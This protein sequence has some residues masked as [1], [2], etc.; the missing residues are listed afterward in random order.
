MCT[1]F[2]AEA[3]G[4]QP[5]IINI[6]GHLKRQFFANVM[7]EGIHET[8]VMLRQEL[9]NIQSKF[10]V[11]DRV[12]EAVLAHN[13]SLEKTNTQLNTVVR[14]LMRRLTISEQGQSTTDHVEATR[15]DTSTAADGS[16]NFATNPN[17][18]PQ[19]IES[20]ADGYYVPNENE[21]NE[22]LLIGMFHLCCRVQISDTLEGETI[23]VGRNEEG[24]LESVKESSD[25]RKRDVFQGVRAYECRCND[26]RLANKCVDAFFENVHPLIPV[27]HKEA[28]Y[29]LYRLYSE[30]ALHSQAK[31]IQ[32]ASSREGRAVALICSVLAL[33]ALT[34]NSD[35]NLQPPGSPSNGP[36]LS[37]FGLA[38]GF[39]STCLRLSAY[40]HDTIETMLAFLFMVSIPT[41]SYPELPMNTIFLGLLTNLGY[42][43]YSF[44]RSKRSSLL[45]ASLIAEGFRRLQQFQTQ[46]ISLNLPFYSKS[47][48][49]ITE[50]Y[51]A[52]LWGQVPNLIILEIVKRAWSV[53]KIY[54]G[55]V[56]LD[57]GRRPDYYDLEMERPKPVDD[58]VSFN[59]SFDVI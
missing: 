28:F 43:C 46:A 10:E 58:A 26:I 55:N 1:T 27:L 29:S 13:R 6:G 8:N 25:A 32:D 22:D 12:H 24:D 3:K 9:D 19:Q 14:E 17:H 57:L 5:F 40:T 2:H 37:R 49:S 53:F 21:E 30:K 34:L 48:D 50:V 45:Q 44:D 33:G 56:Y 51:D 36:Q 7:N 18:M 41:S 42:L 54:L 52:E 35:E 23:H 59:I 38:F 20:G 31:N 11:Q 4:P 47:R 39:Y 16:I 15:G